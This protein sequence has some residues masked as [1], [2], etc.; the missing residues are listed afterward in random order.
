MKI[1]VTD[2]ISAS[3]IQALEDKGFEVINTKVAQEQL[4]NYINDHTI[5]AITVG[6]TTQVRQELIDA[7]PSIKLIAC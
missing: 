2:G 4:E 3:G 7:C 6:N 5:D 1:L